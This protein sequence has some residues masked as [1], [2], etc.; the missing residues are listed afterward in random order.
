LLEG[1]LARHADLDGDEPVERLLLGLLAYERALLGEPAAGPVAMA[2]RA[3]AGG[4]LLAD[5]GGIS[6]AFMMVVC[7]LLVGDELDEARKEIESG[8]ADARSR[9]D[10]LDFAMA[11]GFRSHAALRAGDVAVAEADGRSALNL[12]LDLGVGLL[13]PMFAAYLVEALVEAGQL[14]EADAV[15]HAT[16]LDGELP[17]DIF[18]ALFIHLAIG[19]L[20]LARGRSQA[21]VERLM[22]CTSVEERWGSITPAVVPWRSWAAIAMGPG[23]RAAE[24]AAE[25]LRRARATCTGRSIGIALHAAAMATEGG[26]RE[27]LLREAVSTLEDSPDRLSHAR[28]LA[29]LGAEL[30]SAGRPADAQRELRKA[31][32]IAH[33]SGAGLVESRCR[34]ELRATGARPRRPAITGPAALTESERRVAVLAARGL[35]NVEIAQS[36][37]VTIK[38]V[39]GHLAHCYRKLA[40]TSR[41]QLVVALDELLAPR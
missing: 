23:A 32:D 15:V 37:F 18:S 11:S 33:R 2:R 26:G 29:E 5:Q 34:S 1:S 9:G 7:V 14:D 4:V 10:A 22:L 39:E 13:V 20:L 41:H 36:L 21:A 17:F 27:R 40:I 35:S 38:T 19:R 12:A 28:A 6:T 8:L 30:R 16:G 31:L 24:L 3:L 25:D